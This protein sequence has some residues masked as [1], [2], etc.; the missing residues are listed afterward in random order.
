MIFIEGLDSQHLRRN[1]FYFPFDFKLQSQELG[2]SFKLALE[3]VKLIILSE[4]RNLCF[5]KD[6]NYRL[7]E[8]VRDIDVLILAHRRAPTD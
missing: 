8:Y 1:L 5:L 2:S 4:F 6:V 3:L 7:G